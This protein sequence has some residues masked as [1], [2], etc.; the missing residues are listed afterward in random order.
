VFDDEIVPKSPAVV[1]REV[2]EPVPKKPRMPPTPLTLV[3]AQK[4]PRWLVGDLVWSKVS[5]HPWWPCMISYDPYLG[6]Y[7]RIQ[8]K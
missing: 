3:E 8:G 4:P 5:G 2:K 7:T 1:K 6:I